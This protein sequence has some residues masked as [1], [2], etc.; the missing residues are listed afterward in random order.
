M[1]RQTKL[2]VAAMLSAAGVPQFLP[3]K[4][5]RTTE[6]FITRMSVTKFHERKHTTRTYKQLLTLGNNINLS[7]WEIRYLVKRQLFDLREIAATQPNCPKS[8]LVKLGAQIDPDKDIAIAKTLLHNKR[9]PKKTRIR[10]AL[11]WGTL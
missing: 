3:P 9:V 8:L 7:K 1:E 2:K 11:E 4:E 10:W 5:I 6:S